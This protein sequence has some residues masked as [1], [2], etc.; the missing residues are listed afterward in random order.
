MKKLNIIGLTIL[1]AGALLIG[2]YAG[3]KYAIEFLRDTSIP[4]IVRYG[5]SAII[6]GLIILLI[7]LVLE[8]IKDK[9]R[10]K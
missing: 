4:G 2:G 10:E 8:R 3:Y 1:L 5:L 6:I 7:S 9:K